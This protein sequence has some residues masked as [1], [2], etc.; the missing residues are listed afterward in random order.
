MATDIRFQELQKAV[1]ALSKQVVRDADAIHAHAI[2]IMEEADDTTRTAEGIAAL[3]VDPATV[4]ETQTLAREMRALSHT[5]HIYRDVA[6]TTAKSATAAAA[7][8]QASHG[9][10]AEAV[11]RSEVQTDNLHREWLREE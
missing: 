11:A 5:A 9:G 1:T 7:Q 10:I 3:G 6:T 4:A 2:H 8:N